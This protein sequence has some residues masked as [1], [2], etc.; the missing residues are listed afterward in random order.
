MTIR[1]CFRALITACAFSAC[2]LV[3]AAPTLLVTDGILMG[4][5]GVTVNG[6]LYN[7][8]FAD[9][10]CNSLFNGCVQSAFTFGTFQS[11]MSA[12]QALIDQVLVDGPAGQFDSD[13]SLTFGC[14]YALCVTVFPYAFN[15]NYP[16]TSYALGAVV[17]N[18]S[19]SP[20]DEFAQLHANDLDTT[21][22]INYNYAIFELATA[23]ANVPEPSSIALFGLALAGMAFKRRRKA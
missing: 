13:P 20:G 3:N 10:S 17:L 16:A 18:Y 22:L 6:T 14:S 2:A 11:A 19:A 4:A 15:P 23:D 12:G 7:V 5:N 8:R 21:S 1:T 9:G